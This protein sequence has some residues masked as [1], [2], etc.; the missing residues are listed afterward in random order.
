MFRHS[1]DV[2]EFAGKSA[3][4]EIIDH[5]TGGWGHVDI[6][7]IVF[8]QLSD[9]GPRR[10]VT[11]VAKER[12]CDPGTLDRWVMALLKK[13]NAAVTMPLSAAGSPCPGR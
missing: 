1:W 6:D 4:L 5:H 2:A 8:T 3:H 7:H 13:E 12:D 11:V 10:N 9:S